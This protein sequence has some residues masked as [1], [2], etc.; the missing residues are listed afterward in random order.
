MPCARISHESSPPGIATGSSFSPAPLPSTSSAFYQRG[1]REPKPLSEPCSRVTRALTVVL[2]RLTTC[3]PCAGGLSW[4]GTLFPRCD[5]LLCHPFPA[6]YP[7][8]R[9]RLKPPSACHLRRGCTPPV[10]HPAQRSPS[11]SDAAIR[12]QPLCFAPRRPRHDPPL[13]GYVARC[14][15]RSLP[16]LPLAP[17]PPCKPGPPH[18]DRG[19]ITPDHVHRR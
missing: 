3:S 14:A 16:T 7:P 6:A 18:A 2:Y 10:P 8:P 11:T 15:A 5:P 9:P 1:T 4:L 12:S 17:R 13:C 19:I